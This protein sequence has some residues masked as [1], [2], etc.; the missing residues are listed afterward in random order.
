MGVAV[1]VRV[2]AGYSRLLGV[3][4]VFG[5]LGPLSACSFYRDVPVRDKTGAVT[6][7]LET[8]PF[9]ITTGD[10]IMDPGDGDIYELTVVPCTETHDLETY[11]VTYLPE[12]EY[13]GEDAVLEASDAFCLD[14][15]ER[16]IGLRYEESVLDM[17]TFYPTDQ[18][19]TWKGDRE[20]ICLAGEY[21][22]AS[23]PG[24][25]KGAGR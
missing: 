4:L 15:F 20:V 8:N 2:P 16:F 10:C 9:S 13:P 24:S 14:E 3:L 11:A 18:T 21:E 1:N 6:E 19:W 12:G 23:A 5:L 7:E 22:G 17:Y 25:L